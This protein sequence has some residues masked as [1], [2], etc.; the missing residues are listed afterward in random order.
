MDPIGGLARKGRKILNSELVEKLSRSLGI[1]NSFAGDLYWKVMYRLAGDTVKMSAGGY[2]ARIHCGNPLELQR[3]KSLMGERHILE[4]LLTELREDDVF[5]DVGAN[6]GTYCLLAAEKTDSE[7]VAFEPHP[8][9]YRRLRENVKLNQYNTQVLEYGLYDSGETKKLSLESQEPGTGTPSLSDSRDSVE[10]QTVRGDEIIEKENL[11][12]P[13]VI[14]IDIEGAEAR[15]LEGLK[16][17]ISD[18]E[19]RLVYCEVHPEGLKNFGNTEEQV[20]QT[21]EEAGFRV[22]RLEQRVD[23]YFI[24]AEK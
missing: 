18:S 14:K 15:A 21:L 2:T 7:V 9:N 17:A 6:I 5:Y 1:D 13:D 22:Q 10:I 12:Y 24:K 3:A 8:A 16:K 11:P 23:Q 4:D 20:E 19:C